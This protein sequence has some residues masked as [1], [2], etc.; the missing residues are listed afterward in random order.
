L[1]DTPDKITTATGFTKLVCAAL[2]TLLASPIKELNEMKKRY[3][4]LAMAGAGALAAGVIRHQARANEYGPPWVE[5]YETSHRHFHIDAGNFP[6]KKN[7]QIVL[8]AFRPAPGVPG[9][10]GSHWFAGHAGPVSNADGEVSVDFVVPDFVPCGQTLPFIACDQNAIVGGCLNWNG[11]IGS[12]PEIVTANPSY[13]Y[14][15]CP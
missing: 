2:A 3:F 8:G 10:S 1:P 14:L 9:G 15:S 5:A 7:H 11:P 6:L 4:V 13:N 12:I